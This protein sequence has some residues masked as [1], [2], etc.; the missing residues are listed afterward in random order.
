V[1]DNEEVKKDNDLEQNKENAQGVQKHGARDFSNL[2][3]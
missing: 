1:D 3:G 2:A